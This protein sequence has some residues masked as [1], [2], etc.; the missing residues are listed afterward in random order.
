MH[1]KTWIETL[2]RYLQDQKIK[3]LV[4]GLSGGV[5]SVVLLDLVSQIKNVPVSAVHVNHQLHP[6]SDEYES[7]C[8]ALGK[9]YQLGVH[10][11]RWADLE[12]L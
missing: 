12:I 7:F 3:R 6:R 9:K 2:L 8:I 11:Q 5:D 10:C 1:E 4:V